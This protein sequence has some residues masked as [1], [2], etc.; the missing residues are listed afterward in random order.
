MTTSKRKIKIGNSTFIINDA[1]N[2]MTDEEIRRIAVQWLF[3]K[4]VKQ[5]ENEMN[6]FGVAS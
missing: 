4:N 1:P 2:S 6:G 3:N 5:I